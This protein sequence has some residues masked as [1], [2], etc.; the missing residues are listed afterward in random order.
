MYVVVQ[1]RQYFG[2]HQ[3]RTLVSNINGGA[4]KFD[5][6]AAAQGWIKTAEAGRYDLSHNESGRP[7]YQ[8]WRADAKPLRGL[9]AG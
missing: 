4:R 2:P 6:R 5:S 8:V 7:A 1:T 9:F 3:T